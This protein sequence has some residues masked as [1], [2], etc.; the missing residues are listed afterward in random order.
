MSEHLDKFQWV[1][2]Y[3]HK[4][5]QSPQVCKRFIFKLSTT[6]DSRLAF[7]LSGSSTYLRERER[8]G[9]SVSTLVLDIYIQAYLG[10]IV[11]LVPD[12]C[13]KANMAVKRVKWFSWFLSAYKSYAYTP[14]L[15]LKCVE[16]CLKKPMYTLK[17]TWLLKNANHHVS[18]QQL[19]MFLLM[20]G[21]LAS[22]LV[23]ADWLGWWLLKAGV[24]VAIC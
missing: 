6:A 9:V 3:I 20:A 4:M 8:E 11:G 14:L 17:N 7:F 15:S 19:A 21:G 24:A 18:I 12:H 2:K 23:A 1:L 13:N 16:L 5:A 10:D 22:M